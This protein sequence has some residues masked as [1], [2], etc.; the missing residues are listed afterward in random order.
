[1]ILL[2][3]VFGFNDPAKEL[4]IY[5]KS[6]HYMTQTLRMT[7]AWLARKAKVKKF[8]RNAPQRLT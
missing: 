8:G 7:H 6:A 2:I 5:R 1:M 3:N 4:P